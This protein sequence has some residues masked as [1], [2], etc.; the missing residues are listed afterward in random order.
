MLHRGFFMKVYDSKFL[1][2]QLTNRLN[3]KVT[4]SKDGVYSSDEMALY[5]KIYVEGK[6]SGVLFDIEDLTEYSERGI[7]S[8]QLDKLAAKLNNGA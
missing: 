4:L 8:S 1:E 6:Y 5:K 7:L 2:E 3:K